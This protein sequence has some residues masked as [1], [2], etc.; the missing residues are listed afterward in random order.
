[1]EEKK[2][3][4]TQNHHILNSLFFNHDRNPAHHSA[5]HTSLILLSLASE[6]GFHDEFCEK[7]DTEN[8]QLDKKLEIIGHDILNR[9]GSIIAPGVLLQ[10]LA[11]NHIPQDIIITKVE[12]RFAYPLLVPVD[13]GSKELEV[14]ISKQEDFPKINYTIKFYATDIYDKKIIREKNGEKIQIPITEMEITAFPN[15]ISPEEIYE[16]FTKEHFTK[17]RKAKKEPIYTLSH[18]TYISADDDDCYWRSIQNKNPFRR[19]KSISQLELLA[20]IPR[21]LSMVADKLENESPGNYKI[22]ERELD[23]FIKYAEKEKSY[24]RNNGKN[25]EERAKE[26]SKRLRTTYA[27]QIIVF[28]PRMRLGIDEHFDLT[29]QLSGKIKRGMHTFISEAAIKDK[30]LF[31]DESKIIGSPLLTDRVI[32]Y[33]NKINYSVEELELFRYNKSF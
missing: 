32:K 6:K 17:L 14:Q 25:V 24:E 2:Y 19:N 29:V 22:L 4:I 1:M 9:E 3:N 26:L 13:K 10:S 18:D 11:D 15:N 23:P 28:D 12:T 20:K 21:I 30:T 5:V 27:R 33:L 16:S 8:Q 31:I 7:K